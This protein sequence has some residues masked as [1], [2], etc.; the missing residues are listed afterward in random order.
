MKKA[1]TL[2]LAAAFLVSC[3]DSAKEVAPDAPQET[4]KDTIVTDT[5]SVAGRTENTGRLL[6]VNDVPDQK[7]WKRAAAMASAPDQDNYVS[8][9]DKITAAKA[10]SQDQMFKKYKALKKGDTLKV[11]FKSRIH[12]VCKKKGCWMTLDLK[13]DQRAFVKFRDYAFFVPL[14]ADNSEAIVSGKAFIDVESVEELKHYAK[15]GGKSQ[16]EI[17]KI[18]KPKVTYAFMADGVLIKK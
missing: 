1:L 4:G 9:G 12:A 18:T 17:D 6:A 5:S 10:L 13:D 16:A 14:N 15:D 11:K 3:K 2:A 8:F 7:Q